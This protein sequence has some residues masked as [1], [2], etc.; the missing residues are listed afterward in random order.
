MSYRAAHMAAA[1]VA[2]VEAG[3][4]TP[5]AVLEAAGVPWIASGFSAAQAT[6]VPEEVQK[7]QTEA[8]QCMAVACG[9]A[10]RSTPPRAS[11]ASPKHGGRWSSLTEC[12]LNARL[13]TGVDLSFFLSRRR[14]L[15]AS[16][17]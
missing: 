17:T 6:V 15:R 8:R 2:V 13:E 5:A 11:R 3:P 12:P 16:L 4:K 14:R 7:W 10:R 9:R 1:A